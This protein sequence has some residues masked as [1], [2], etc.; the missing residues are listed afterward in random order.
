MRK[1]YG[2][3]QLSD[4]LPNGYYIVGDSEG[5]VGLATKELVEDQG[6]SLWQGGPNVH[7]IPL[8]S[9]GYCKLAIPTGEMM[10]DQMQIM[11]VETI[12]VQKYIIECRWMIRCGYSARANT[13]VVLDTPII[14]M[15]QRRPYA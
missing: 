11:E 1:Q 5:W 13:W 12:E 15:N 9:G 2:I 7:K 3:A 6:D 4:L 14:D 8:V 10:G